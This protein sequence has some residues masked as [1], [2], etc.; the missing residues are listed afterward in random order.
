MQK[1]GNAMVGNVRIDTEGLSDEEA[2]LSTIEQTRPIVEEIKKMAFK[3]IQTGGCVVCPLW[4]L[5]E[6]ALVINDGMTGLGFETGNLEEAIS[7]IRDAAKEHPLWCAYIFYRNNIQIYFAE[8]MPEPRLIRQAFPTGA[9]AFPSDVP[10]VFERPERVHLEDINITALLRAFEY[11]GLFI[12]VKDEKSDAF[13]EILNAGGYTDIS[14][15]KDTGDVGYKVYSLFSA[16]EYI[17]RSVDE[18]GL[19]ALYYFLEI[20]EVM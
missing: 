3:T 16:S 8:G 11:E 12:A 4:A 19:C 20:V 14:K 18:L 6:I 7:S 5:P 10:I 1:I 13:E 9:F 17:V 2:V 15:G